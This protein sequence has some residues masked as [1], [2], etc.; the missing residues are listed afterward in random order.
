MFDVQ[1]MDRRSPIQVLA[2]R[3]AWASATWVIAWNRIP[4]THLTLWIH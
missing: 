2:Q 4:T 1:A 3:E